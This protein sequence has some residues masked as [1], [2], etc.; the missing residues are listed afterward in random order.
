MGEGRAEGSS[1]IRDG[2]QAPASNTFTF[3]SLV[4]SWHS[5]AVPATSLTLAS[6]HPGLEIKILY[7]CALYSTVR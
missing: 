3:V 5:L 4:T 1:A 6:G 2:G 7:Y